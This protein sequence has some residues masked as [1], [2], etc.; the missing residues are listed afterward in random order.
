MLLLYGQFNNFRKS[1][2]RKPIDWCIPLG[3]NS[4]WEHAERIALKIRGLHLQKS[5]R[6]EEAPIT[7]R[8][9][10]EQ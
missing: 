3:K 9:G 2:K 1:K 7:P 6:G 10:T 8:P 5:R 4:Y